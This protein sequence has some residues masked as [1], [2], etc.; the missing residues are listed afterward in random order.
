MPSSILVNCLWQSS[1]A[2]II[3][4]FPCLVVG[5]TLA[6]RI[7]P[8]LRISTSGFLDTTF[9]MIH[10]VICFAFPITPHICSSQ[11]RVSP[12]ETTTPKSIGVRAI[13]CQG[14]GGAVNHLPRKFLQVAQI[15]TKQSNRNEGRCNNIGRTGI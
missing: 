1:I 4:Q 10:D 11:Q 15:F 8:A 14:G 6:L 7:P 5:A 9:L 12:A 2:I 3:P 13:F